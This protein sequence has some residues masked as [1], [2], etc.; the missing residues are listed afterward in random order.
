MKNNGYRS[1]ISLIF[2][3]AKK[4]GVILAAILALQPAHGEDI[5][6][7]PQ[8]KLPVCA[9]S[10]GSGHLDFGKS[11]RGQLQDRSGVLSAGSKTITLNA[12]CTLSRAMRLRINGLAR[13]TA[14]SWGHTDSF[15]KISIRQAL[16][17]GNPVQLQRMS[18]NGALSGGDSDQLSLLPGDIFQPVRSS[19]PVSGKHLTATLEIE[20]IIGDKDSRPVQQALSEISLNIALLP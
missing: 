9:V 14:F 11:S 3:P 8:P 6:G 18:R 17:D 4:T 1:M 5:Q 2:V 13:G 15:L 12:D 7:Y 19:Q 16:L 20:P 10:A